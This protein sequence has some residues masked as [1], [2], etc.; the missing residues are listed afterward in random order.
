MMQRRLWV[1]VGI[2]LLLAGGCET[3]PDT[4]TA[5]GIKAIGPAHH[6]NIRVVYQIK[7]DQDKKGVGA[8][9][10]YIRKLLDTYNAVGI[11]DEAVTVHGVF[12]G[13]AGHWMLNDSAYAQAAST[14]N[15]NPNQAIIRELLERG[16]KLELCA[17]TMRSHNWQGSDVIDGVG[18][19]YGAYPRIIDLQLNGFA[20]IRF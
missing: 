2:C 13:D 3:Q 10:F 9:L 15:T 4:I 7:T 11:P 12:H 14:G 8:G 20:Y 19:V 6:Q 16:V 17:Q 1:A 18:V 5:G